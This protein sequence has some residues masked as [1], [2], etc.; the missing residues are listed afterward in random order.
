LT[1]AT[2]LRHSFW[3]F[4]AAARLTWFAQH[5]TRALWLDGHLLLGPKWTCLV[6]YLC[7]HLLA[8]FAV[9]CWHSLPTLYAGLRFSVYICWL[10]RD[11]LARRV[12]SGPAPWLP[13]VNRGTPIYRWRR[14]FSITA[15]MTSLTAQHGARVALLP[16]GFLNITAVS[17]RREHRRT[18]RRWIG[19][20]AAFSALRFLRQHRRAC[21]CAPVCAGAVFSLRWS[22]FL[23]EGASFCGLS[24]FV[25][26]LLLCLCSY[27]PLGSSGYI[28]IL[29]FS[30]TL[31]WF[32]LLQYLNLVAKGIVKQRRMS[33]L[34]AFSRQLF[35]LILFFSTAF[36]RDCLASFSLLCSACSLPMFVP[37][38][39]AFTATCILLPR[40]LPLD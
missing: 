20:I 32:H 25:N 12:D 19:C 11:G 36:G 5:Q 38:C 29:H 16:G 37:S 7:L 26:G 34:P 6:T 24:P 9:G 39:C 27:V 33:Y 30:S 31:S 14:L 1:A 40:V 8:A 2:D 18:R 3:F 10:P 23:R 15:R 35:F 13:L 4:L 17:R 22:S 21:V 28:Y